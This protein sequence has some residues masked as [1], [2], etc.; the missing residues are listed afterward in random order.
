VEPTD[1]QDGAASGA[2]AIEP[3]AAVSAVTSE[4]PP[5]PPM[6]SEA[7]WGLSTEPV[8]QG[9]GP[10]PPPRRSRARLFLVGGAILVILGIVIGVVVASGGGGEKPLAELSPTGTPPPSASPTVAPPVGFTATGRSVPF[11]VVMTWSAPAGEAVQGY[12]IY[13]EGVQIATVP[14]ETT[15]YTD[16]NVKPGKSYTYEI[17]TRGDGL[18]QSAR[19]SSVVDVPIPP[20]SSARLQGTF[21][22]KMKT[23]SQ[24]GY[25]GNLGSFTLGWNFKPKCSEGSCDVTWKD[26]VYKEFK[27]TLH[28]KG[29]NYSGSDSG[30]FFGTCSGAKGISS[31]SLT[32]HVVKAKVIDGE[33]RA[34]KLEGTM[35]ES[36]AS[37]FGCVSGGAHFT[38]TATLGG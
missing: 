13:R 37:A 11:G 3:P 22:A 27:T 19:V 10:P 36:H 17:V 26:L 29:V 32:V 18:V 4:I 38:V 15:T 7:P 24:S 31:L 16:S 12:R 2:D 25:S 6:P 21:N 1:P 35:V 30:T 14:S 34:T 28:R 20:L 33:W 8:G 9:A 5:P 23:T